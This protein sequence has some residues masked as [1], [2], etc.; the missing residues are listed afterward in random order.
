MPMRS[1]MPFL[2]LIIHLYNQAIPISFNVAFFVDYPLSGAIDIGISH[3]LCNPKK[4]I[5]YE[6]QYKQEVY[7]YIC[8]RRR[9]APSIGGRLFI[10]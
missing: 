7:T 3:S 10:N 4:V 6:N 5:L 2:S 8:W 1:Q 9:K